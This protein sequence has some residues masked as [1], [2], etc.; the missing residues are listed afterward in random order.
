MNT[1]FTK[2]LLLLVAVVGIAAAAPAQSD[3]AILAP[4]T[5]ADHRRD[6]A[7]SSSGAVSTP[8]LG[9]VNHPTD[10]YAAS[11]WSLQS[12]FASLGR[13]LFDHINGLRGWVEMVRRAL[14]GK[15]TACYF[16]F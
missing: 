15:C 2:V 14:I 1:S 6:G 12:T 10:A 16:M 3:V 7:A 11:L 9:V 13:S 5:A 4:S 8:V